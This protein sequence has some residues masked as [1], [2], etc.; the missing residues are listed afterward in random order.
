MAAIPTHVREV[1]KA[2]NQLGE[3]ASWRQAER[4]LYWVNCDH[5]AE[6]LRWSPETGQVDRWPMPERIGGFV[7]RTDGGMLVVLASGLFD[8]DI[9]TGQLERLISSPLPPN[10]A[11][12]EAGCDRTGR[13]WV[14]SINH[15][16]TAQ[17]L[18]PGG[19]KLFRVEKGELVELDSGISCSNGLA[20]SG[21][22]RCVYSCDT[23]A[24]QVW[25]REIDED[26][27][28]G[29]RQAFVVIPHAEGMVDGA[30]IDVEG[31]YWAAM[32]I[33]GT[34]RRYRPDG[35]LDKEFALPFSAPTKVTFG[36]DGMDQLFVTTCKLDIPGI[37]AAS[38]SGNL[39]ALE[40][41]YV[42]VPDAMLDPTTLP[43]G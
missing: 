9:G 29:P 10:I 23:S 19:G 22:G 24:A 14:G 7:H 8:F 11:L 21:D 5:P 3:S 13:L 1:L 37:I 40:P 25:R 28:V 35:T 17:N 34:V 31:G 39:Y 6:L 18:N 33:A 4:R 36:G 42:G 15:D 20:F 12:H 27:T 30:T 43:R 16:I 26:G 32:F 2:D 38:T 41:G